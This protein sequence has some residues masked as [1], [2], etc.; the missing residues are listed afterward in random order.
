MIKAVASTDEQLGLTKVI[1]VLSLMG[2]NYGFGCSEARFSKNSRSFGLVHSLG[3]SA[4]PTTIP[5]VLTK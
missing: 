3:P 5:E 4:R 1:E 2:E